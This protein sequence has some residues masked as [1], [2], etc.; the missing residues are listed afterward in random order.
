MLKILAATLQNV[1]ALAI[2]CPRFVH[3]CLAVA[4]SRDNKARS[5]WADPEYENLMS[6]LL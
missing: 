1:V 2:N 6:T 3:P 4:L 5:Y